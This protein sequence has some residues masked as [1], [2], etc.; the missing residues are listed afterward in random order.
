VVETL[1]CF[2]ILVFAII[3]AI[4]MVATTLE[5]TTN[6]RILP[7]P[8]WPTLPKPKPS[9]RRDL[10][11]SQDDFQ[12]APIL[13]PEINGETIWKPT[14]TVDSSFLTKQHVAVRIKC[15]NRAE[16]GSTVGV[17]V[18]VSNNHPNIPVKD[19]AVLILKMPTG[20]Q[21]FSGP[22]TLELR[23]SGDMVSVFYII[24]VPFIKGNYFIEFRLLGI[25]LVASR[26]LV[27]K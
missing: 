13:Q 4:V 16:P 6:R 11:I 3:G 9:R 22:N 27:V 21:R 10:E 24:E 7:E 2:I 19:D 15:L 17:R 14:P 25:G 12:L 5:I 8:L 18:D 20:V 26:V 23:P 1:V